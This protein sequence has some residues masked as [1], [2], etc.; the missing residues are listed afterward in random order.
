[1]LQGGCSDY[2]GAITILPRSHK[3]DLLS[4]HRMAQSERGVG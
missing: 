3:Y 4:P 2:N 1:M